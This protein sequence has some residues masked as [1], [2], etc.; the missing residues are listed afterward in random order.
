MLEKKK[1]KNSTFSQREINF[2]ITDPLHQYPSFKFPVFFYA[3]LKK[4]GNRESVG[5]GD[6]PP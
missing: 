5:Q 4:D 6:G 3:L 2:F 1:P